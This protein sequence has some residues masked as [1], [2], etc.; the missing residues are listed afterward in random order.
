MF[1]SGMK[2]S[3]DSIRPLQKC[4]YLSSSPISSVISYLQNR[5][6]LTANKSQLLVSLNET[7]CTI[8]YHLH[9]LKDVKNTHGRELLLVKLQAEVC[10]FTKSKTPPWRFFTLFK[11][12]KCTKRAKRL[13]RVCVTTSL[14]RSD[15]DHNLL[16]V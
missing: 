7:L 5:F 1:L 6:F 12:C 10:N 4:S 16:T 9:N 15:F 11:L 14:V 2:V 3:G 13:K 8:Q